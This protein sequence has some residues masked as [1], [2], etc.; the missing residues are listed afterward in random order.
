MPLIKPPPT[1]TRSITQRGWSQPCGDKRGPWARLA[2]DHTAARLL[3]PHRR[4]QPQRL[5]IF[6]G[7]CPPPPTPPLPPP[8]LHPC[9]SLV[10]HTQDREGDLP[11]NVYVDASGRAGGSREK[12]VGASEQA[13]IKEADIWRHRHRDKQRLTRRRRCADHRL[14][15]EPPRRRHNSEQF[16]DGINICP[17]PPQASVCVTLRSRRG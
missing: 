11:L 13:N 3:H 6:D 17:P 5:A 7:P 10:Q 12:V 9:C 8:L 15:L 1:T 4:A 14:T 2:G 16:I